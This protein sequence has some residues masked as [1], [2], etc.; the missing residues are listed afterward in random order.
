MPKQQQPSSV[1]DDQQ[2]LPTYPP[3][4]MEL[5]VDRV[6]M[7]Q[8]LFRESELRFS[9]PSY[10]VDLLN[11]FSESNQVT[12]FSTIATAL[13]VFLFRYTRQEELLIWSESN[14]QHQM[15]PSYIAGEQ[16]FT[17]LKIHMQAMKEMT[18]D[19]VSFAQ[20]ILT[21]Q[22]DSS[23]Q[24]S[25]EYELK[26]ALD[27]GAGEWLGTL[28]YNAELFEKTTIERMATHFVTLLQGIAEHP[29]L[30]VA[31]LPMLTEGERHQLLSLWNQTQADFPDGCT[32][33][34]LFEAQVA[35]T[36]DALALIFEDETMTYAEL[37]QRANQLAHYL[38]G[39]GVGP[40]KFVGICVERSLEMIVC[41]M[42]VL[43]A[44]GA[45]VPLDPTYPSERLANML[46]D[47]QP[48]VLLTQ[49][50]VLA[51]LPVVDG[52]RVVCVDTAWSMIAQE[53]TDN[54]VLINQAIDL[55]YVI[56]TSGSTGRPK[57]TM[58]EHR[59]LCNML[60][61][62]VSVFEVGADTRFLQ[63]ASFS[64]DV[65]VKEIFTA[66]TGGATLCM[67]KKDTLMPG[68][69]FVA[70][71]RDKKINTMILSP[72]VLAML[73]PE[74]LP[75]MRI[76]ITGGE[77]IS[78]ELAS[79]WASHVRY[80]N[81][82][83][84]TEATVWVTYAEWKP[85]SERPPLGRGIR[86][87]E[88]Y[89][90][91]ERM[92]PVPIGV[93]GELYI[94]SVGLARGYLN[95]P[96]LTAEKF[97]RHPF[98]EQP[99][100]R[101]YRSGDL[102]RYRADGQLEFLGRVDHQVKIRGFRIELGEIEEM[103]L[104]HHQVEDVLVMAR[105][106]E[107]GDKRLVAYVVASEGK[108]TNDELRSHLQARL[109]DFM[110]PAAFVLLERFPLTPNGKVDR[111]ALPQPVWESSTYVAPRTPLEETLAEIWGEVFGSKK[112]G[113]LDHFLELGGHSLSA[114]QILARVRDR[115][116]IEVTLKQ[117]FAHPTI[118]AFAAQ[119]EQDRL[120]GKLIEVSTIRKR[121]QTGDAPMSMSQERVWFIHQINDDHLSY[122]AQA[123]F[124]CKG[125]LRVDVL[126]QC[127]TELVRRHEIYR[128][129]FHEVD[130]QPVQR[131]HPPFLVRVP[132]IS[133]TDVP[134]AEQEAEVQKRIH[135]EIQRYFD[136]EQL[137]LF[138]FALYKLSETEHVLLHMEQHM[139]HD[140]WSYNVFL[141]EL[142]ELYPAFLE[143][144]P[145]PLAEPG[146]QFADYAQWQQD[147]LQS[148]E[149]QKQLAYW[150][151][152][153]AG[154]PPMLQIPT[155]F[156]HPAVPSYLGRSF[157]VGL[158]VELTEELNRLSR[159]QGVTL[160][161]TM[162]SVFYTLLHRYT[163]QDD[164]VI[165]SG[166]ANR[167]LKETEN[168]IGMI[169]N[170]IALRARI[171][172]QM[173]FRELINH[174]GSMTL[175]AYAHEDLPFDRVVEALNP[176]RN[177]G[178]HPLYQV[179][180]SFHDSAMP[181]MKL[182]DLEVES[183]LALNSGTAKFDMNIV[184]IPHPEP[185]RS[186]SNPDEWIG[187]TLIWDTSTDLW[188]EATAS[189][190]L[191]HYLNLLKSVVRNPDQTLTEIPLM[192]GE[193]Q[194]RLL[195]GWSEPDVEGT[196][197]GTTH[198]W[199]EK[200]AAE[201]PD[202]TAVVFGEESLT[203]RELN[204]RANQLAHY[205]RANGVQTGDMVGLFLER[206][207]EVIVSVLAVMKAGGAYVPI[208]PAY[209]QERL[210]ILLEDT[211][212]SVLLSVRRLT[213]RLPEHGARVI[214]LDLEQASITGESVENLA[215]TVSRDQAAYVIF[216]SGSTGRPKGVAVP[217]RGIV[218]LIKGA[219]FVT[220]SEDET[221]LQFAPISFDA[222][223][224]EMW[225]ALLS[226]G[227]LVIFPPHMPTLEELGAFLLEH[228]ITTLFL[229]TGLFHQMV[230]ERL[231]DLRY[232]R[233]LLSGGD[234][235]S[236]AHVTKVLER[237]P[238][239]TFVNCYGPTENAVFTTVYVLNDVAQVGSSVSI[240]RPVAGTQVYVLDGNLQPVPAGVAGELCTSGDGL[241]DGYLHRPE[242]TAEKFVPHPFAA[243]K[244][245]LLYRTGDLVRWRADGNLEFVGRIDN[246]VKIR[247][248]RIELGE[249]ETRL[250]L[251][252][253]VREVAV[254]A[255]QDTP[256][257]K[258]L[259]A[260]LVLERDSNIT[261]QELRNELKAALPEYMIPS[262]FVTLDALPLTHNGKV[263]YRALPAPQLADIEVRDYTA[264]RN[265][266]EERIASVF[267]SVLNVGQLSVYDHFFEVGGHSLL[268]MRT[269]SKLRE[270]LQVELPLR[271]LFDAP[272][273][274]E[275]ALYIEELQ[276]GVGAAGMSAE[277]VPVPRT[278]EMPLS[279]SQQRLWFLDRFLPE[280]PVY[281]I[282]FAMRVRG[283]LN[284]DALQK[285]VQ[286][287]VAR[288]E[289]LRTTF[290]E[291]D[292][293][294]MQVIAPQQE[295]VVSLV[296][297]TE[298]D[299]AAREELAERLVHEEA[300]RPFD[301]VNGPL[302]R[303]SVVRLH[304]TEHVLILNQHHIIS[305]GWSMGVL[306]R[307]LKA[308]YTAYLQ[309]TVVELAP[310][311][312]QYADY[313]VWQREWL[314]GDVLE[315][316][317]AYWKEQL[318][319]ELPILQ[320]PT[321][322]P[323]PPVKTY[324]GALKRFTLPSASID[325][326]KRLSGEQGVTLFM[327]MLTAFKTLLYRYT[328][329]TDL[330]VG[331]PIAGRNRAELEGLIGF[332]V[333]TLVFRT[334]F[335][336]EPTFRDLLIRVRDMV[337]AAFA[338]QDVPFEKLVEELKPERH[339]AHSP[340]C[341]VMFQ[342]VSGFQLELPGLAVELLEP[343][344]GT[345]KFDLTLTVIEE[346]DEL[347]GRIDYNT[348]LFDA[349]TI[350]RM[351]ENFQTLLTSIVTHPDQ[352]V[353]TLPILSESTR[354][355]LLL[356]GNQATDYPRNFTVAQLFE[357]Q[358]AKT[359]ENVAVVDQGRTITYQE[360]NH[361]A[362]QLA[363][364]LQKVGLGAG[365]LVG[366]FLERSLDSIV[367]ML[368]TL[369]VGGAYVPFDP[370]Y[371]EER[372][373]YMIG[374]TQVPVLITTDELSKRV[375]TQPAH[376]IC[377]DTLANTI[378]DQPTINVPLTG[379][380]ESLA[381]I[382]YTS[383]STGQPKGV[384]V[385][386]RAIVRLVKEQNYVELTERD[387]LL[388]FAPI[389]F[390]ASTF[391]IWGGLLSGG[392]VVVFP[393]HLPTLEE[394]GSF[395]LSH[396]ITTLWLT[397]GL[398]HQM[399]EERLEDLRHVRQLLA[400]GDVL[401]VAH[402]RS[403]L[404]RYPEIKMINGYGP[405]EN[406]T[407]TCC[408]VMREPEQAGN[409]VPIGQ[410][411]HNTQVYILDGQ[412][413][414]VPIGVAGELYTGGDGLAQGYFNRP[415]LTAEKFVPNPFGET[416]SMLYRTGD[417]VRRL[418]N[419]NIEFLGR[420]DNQ[421][422]IRGFRIELG[423]I[424]A[425]LG[426]HPHVSDT[427]VTVREAKPG[428]KRIVAYVVLDQL[429]SVTSRELRYFLKAKLPEYMLPS[430]FVLLQTLPLTH[431]GKVD[432]RA[433]PD[434]TDL[435]GVDAEYVAPRNEQEEKLAAIFAEI[436][437]LNQVGIHDHF[438]DNG[439]HSLLATRVTSRVR[440]VFGI[441]LPLRS[442]FEAP[443]VASL[444]EHLKGL[445]Q[446][447]GMSSQASTILP[448]DR[449]QDLPV[450]F[451]QQRLW[452]LDR[453]M[454]DTG[455]YNMPLALRLQGELNL[456]VLERSL[457][458]IV[459]RHESL[460]TIFQDGEESA[461]QVITSP[462]Q[463]TA[464]VIN[465]EQVPAEHRDA[466][467]LRMLGAEALR[468]FDLTGGPLFRALIWKLNA[469]EH[470]LL[471][472]MHH[473]IS[474][475]WSMGIFMKELAALYEA[476]AK[477]QPSPLPP[478]PIQYAD[479]SFWHREWLKGDVQAEQLGYWKE[480]L[481]GELPVLQLPTDRPRPVV[482]TYHGAMERF[483]IPSTLTGPLRTLSQREGVTLFMTL[484]AAFKTLLYRYTGQEDVI[485]G[486]PIA[487]RNHAEIEGLIGFFVNTLAM[488]TELSGDI[489]FRDLLERVRQTALDA[490]A[491]QE[492]PFE[493]LVEELQPDRD[494]SHAPLFQVLFQIV[495]G[496][497]LQ[498]PGIEVSAVELPTNTAKFDLTMSLVEE[499]DRLVGRLDYNT[500]LFDRATIQRML[501]HFQT[502]LAGIVVNPEQPLSQLPLVSEAMRS[503]LLVEGNEPMVYP[504]ELTV[505]QL[506]EAQVQKTPDH[507][508]VVYAGQDV[509][510]AE[511][512]ARANQLAHTLK[513]AGVGAGTL[514]GI[515]LERSLDAIIAMTA[516]LKAGGTYVPLDPTY[517]PER[518]AYMVEDTQVPVLITLETWQDRLPLHQA[519][520]ILLDGEA[521]AIWH[522]STENPEPIGTGDSLAYIMYTSGSTGQPKGTMVPHRG[523]VR[524]VQP[525]QNYVE[526]SERDVL[527]QFAPI[528]FDASTFEIWGG[529][530]NG[531]R[532]VVFPA[533]L[534]TLEEL[535]R[536][537]LEHG[538][539]TVW[540]TAGLF[541]QMVEERLED[542]RQVR[543]LLAGGDVLSVAHVRKVRE[544]LPEVKMVNGYG[545]TENTTFTCCHVLTQGD[546]VG[547]SVPIG[548]AIGG[549]QV[550]ILD[551]QMQPVP[552]GVA[553]ELYTGG[554]GLAH[555]YFKRP[556]L[557]AEKFV[558]NPFAED[559]HAK[560]YRSGDLVRRLPNGTIEF[561]GRLDS[562]VKIRGFRIELGEV[563]SVLA[564][565]HEVRECCVLVRS[566][567]AGEKRLVAYVVTQ[568]GEAS[569]PALREFVK[570]KL[571][572]YMVP[573]A[574]VSLEALPLT[575]NGKVDQ[576]AL[577][578]P[579]L[580]AEDAPDYVAP[581]TEVEQ[582][583]AM[584][585]Q[586][587]FGVRTVG[588]YDHFFHL[589]GSSLLALKLVSRM[590]HVFQV[591][592]PLQKLFERP[593][594]LDVAAEV[595]T[596]KTSGANE[597][598][599]ASPSIQP[600][601]D[602]YAPCP[603]SFDQEELW[604]LEQEEPGNSVYNVNIVTHLDGELDVAVLERS[605][606]EIVRRHEALRTRF[607]VQAGQPV[608]VVMQDLSL[609][610]T[611]VD[612]DVS[613]LSLEQREA[614]AKHLAVQFAK[615]PFNLNAGPLIRVRLIRKTAVQHTLLVTMHHIITDG[616]SNDVFLRE[617]S[618]L[619]TAFLSGESSPLPELS[620]QFADYVLWQ[621]ETLK[622]E[623]LQQ[624]L[625]YWKQQMSGAPQALHL[626]TDYP[627]PENRT[628]RGTKEPLALPRTLSDQVKELSQREG[629]T[630]FM[631]MLAAF[632]VLLYSHAKQEDI[633]L[634]TPMVNR[635][636][637][638]TEDLIGYLLSVLLMRSDLSGDPTFREL[639]A[640]EHAMVL[641]AFAHKDMP[642]Q[643]LMDELAVD[644]KRRD[645][646]YHVMF[647]YY[648]LQEETPINFP[649]LH[650]R[651]E[652][653]NNGTSEFELMLV[654]GERDGEVN[655][656]FDYN[657]DLFDRATIVRFGKQLIGMLQAIVAN[658]E[659]RVSELAK[660][661]MQ[662]V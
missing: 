78:A 596:L 332:F 388:Q 128:T 347:T 561:L 433:L 307:E 250:G 77:A 412:M 416:G 589:G 292:E 439:G 330:I 497:R 598:G 381:Y 613:H 83:G 15:I 334:D 645:P 172:P 203:Y 501:E 345:A 509:S 143:G 514:V 309:G 304:E 117:L 371:P 409:T 428:D 270:V 553:G 603:L 576:R 302:F 397:A 245:K 612:L 441:E 67:A 635:H 254:I 464:Q 232:V 460:R 23:L 295:L 233:Q 46:E 145:S 577:P 361:R 513:K 33:Q 605:I 133:L 487:G 106:D 189:R 534:P 329:Q 471:L 197:D 188:E 219:T 47:V 91:D 278:G 339:T 98:S 284:L 531:G 629:V 506:F 204:R 579:E 274:A 457:G 288:H 282:P 626:P 543:W 657:T 105:E 615:R 62:A 237:R 92:Q 482:M 283:E 127:L 413:Q 327:T 322:R 601:R 215:L 51:G 369:K 429:L 385:P 297:L 380:S 427:V 201:T 647:V 378:A 118:A 205:L 6:R 662:T 69:A 238:D 86:N 112:M 424:E 101:L 442:L 174:V 593:L 235:L 448:V 154:C 631:T 515:F 469:D 452:F 244:G 392:R 251:H 408:Y 529:L 212:V 567:D 638:E 592:M 563:E 35:R 208:D 478:L 560:L 79:R 492:I 202:H 181:E 475:G 168:L 335:N 71:L 36:P 602:R 220:L 25:V 191:E 550:Y 405:T 516:V 389:A 148:E 451:A 323:H 167:R 349:A 45:Y 312:V 484:L 458:E 30:S 517:P 94:G 68:P 587:L 650:V 386:H 140:G 510:Y 404:E 538:V 600:R 130:G 344:T 495:S 621:R 267:E 470:V 41:I 608:M 296:D 108:L 100:A 221:L 124:H 337:V 630:M 644:E 502:L 542:L 619:Y 523:I 434:P 382:M 144:K 499:G 614:E 511:L 328:G 547:Y 410:A 74:Q 134:V 351:I 554:D 126:E 654:L 319:G 555:G 195:T 217:H 633:V 228:Q 73:S 216:T 213:D 574:Y 326:L 634:G 372:L 548:K 43:K 595:E 261:T 353:A 224:L 246:Q 182:P 586:E 142:L 103:L 539:T 494:M 447:P 95:R 580:V 303:A 321:D 185:Q 223:V 24:S 239:I 268:A 486:T 340:L 414:P 157:R 449:A 474:D 398:F 490:Y 524:L 358:V 173:T 165:G 450:S 84:P 518:L 400:G 508:A 456:E 536:F 491:H 170:N 110:V 26:F 364:H 357:M 421:V 622:G 658:P 570:E 454:P 362:N 396:N 109:P 111:R 40:D 253:E 120:D 646:L 537:I 273:I 363:H 546:E 620:I 500:D 277:I 590:R 190:M 38:R 637:M 54:P 545:P 472:N 180:F 119:M 423:E 125:N 230:E 12:L 97:V 198:E 151:Q 573:A 535:G 565:H 243:E 479:F 446:L 652:L 387:A 324:N 200:Q 138:H 505:Q 599:A 301:L 22:A 263:D 466:E 504:R 575:P 186:E 275:L 320:L 53:S 582:R 627:R 300:Q 444:V 569:L 114:I 308:F 177:L 445:E 393:P 136:M 496:N 271:C 19:D 146:L 632:N 1:V 161:A 14:G 13:H 355:H 354:Q 298:N 72:S 368:A 175:D 56:F 206:S 477:G 176:E 240:G 656:R 544:Q 150:K 37:N 463:W 483:S 60:A 16:A 10:V 227:K 317:L 571:P 123:M 129:T 259:V 316:Q 286:A 616:W 131:I 557:T 199:F 231:D 11:Q 291:T 430:A 48:E 147:W 520:V 532:V 285:S 526:F 104:T 568:A 107:P 196:F 528:A 17:D 209:P 585:W 459:A 648:D 171:S 455:V 462:E 661:M 255:R 247:G 468:G 187:L 521:E 139:I 419:G 391:E 440:Q 519:H 121:E 525:N 318:A 653:V 158:P 5:P 341:Q 115:L 315:Q 411:I 342:I 399:V 87:T 113:V 122:N 32:V 604:Q 406:T 65:S 2:T 541:H 418:P 426:R 360:L 641:E 20:V 594:L 655:G 61:E 366:L 522:E 660:K 461:L 325:E 401:S 431:N 639:L 194:Q 3:V 155:D 623:G 169:V 390:D 435:L 549:T 578:Q 314:Q 34:E 530:L 552:I 276:L 359:P 611:V 132:V 28:F 265:G 137:P 512:N 75:D 488:R 659:I 218:R 85:S 352:S 566:D 331:S 338:N 617:L 207:T 55:V 394:L 257:D 476:F 305:D 485:V 236:V 293:C 149:A 336:D 395:I 562:Q 256:G 99:D 166:V 39:R 465:L 422:K 383:G 559:P 628:Y 618:V 583:L 348:D 402:V 21:L 64:F 407:F 8:Q 564:Q 135:L 558:P 581:R 80:F 18:V 415:D 610:L 417:L 179:M 551:G 229:T 384:M 289:S 9:V 31:E 636:R 584:L 153:L 262:A 162:L 272:T 588:L 81:A 453:F 70:Y 373:T 643:V 306:S 606:Q 248:F 493:A 225:G 625:A 375:P 7:P 432:Y 438:F 403:V 214:H 310:L 164:L 76:V 49:Q 184:S 52:D 572:T 642:V 234:T 374:D 533:H 242:L 264:P 58:L 141:R 241:A 281:N 527:L 82:Y 252:P 489:A 226:G 437:G 480:K 370:A 57:G 503:R 333:N 211:Q 44:G 269:I 96:E 591:E 42:G 29:N 609:P 343:E 156:P 183:K 365:T 280:N 260:Y 160:Y 651:R 287:I 192:S 210:S 311:P 63:F 346:G 163:G 90:L 222:S 4:L 66:L 27:V 50:H 152:Q 624:L 159:E 376:L 481:K 178:I 294:G 649:G 290:R 266:L 59:G 88:L 356:A 350:E 93:A 607:E 443:T 597:V 379:T 473:I 556:D 299:P 116:K 367:A 279:F 507:T 436:L 102:V 89:V 193:E 258:R 498:L 540:L 425:E 313:A 249:I 640:R 420:L 467:C 377:L